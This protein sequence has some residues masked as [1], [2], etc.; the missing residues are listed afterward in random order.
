MTATSTT[1]ENTTTNSEFFADFAEGLH[2]PIL[3]EYFKKIDAQ[4]AQNIATV[5]AEAL[6]SGNE[7]SDAAARKILWKRLTVGLRETD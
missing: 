3:R 2:N 4:H 1:T 6:A 5:K 7:L